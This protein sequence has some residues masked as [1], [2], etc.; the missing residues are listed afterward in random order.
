MKLTPKKIEPETVKVHHDEHGFIGEMNEYEF[1]DFRIQIMDAKAT[2]Y[3]VATDEG[4]SRIN[5]QGRI[6][7]WSFFNLQEE[8]LRKLLKGVGW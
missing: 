1:T 6:E 8:Q 2:G 3:Y 7:K 4:P 5:S